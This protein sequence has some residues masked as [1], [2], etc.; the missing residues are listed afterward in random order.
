MPGAL[1]AER[2]TPASR[3]FYVGDAILPARFTNIWVCSLVPQQELTMT[4]QIQ[5]TTPMSGAT[6][7]RPLDGLPWESQ[8]ALTRWL[9]ALTD[10]PFDAW[11]S[12][13]EASP[14]A[15]IEPVRAR[16]ESVL[17]DQGLSV[18]AW[19][20]RDLVCT[21]AHPAIDA[22]RRRSR[23]DRMLIA[24]ARSSAEWAAL[25]IAAQDW[26]TTT[27]LDALC[28]PFD[29]VIARGALRLVQDS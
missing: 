9:D 3:L 6:A 17:R 20:I 15:G 23:S 21:L 10:L 12:I 16:I 8:Q 13:G 5:S 19:F 11:V 25:A 26:L 22:A 28:A 1:V 27:D 2:P 24:R 14:A 4:H 29:G 7:I 18:A